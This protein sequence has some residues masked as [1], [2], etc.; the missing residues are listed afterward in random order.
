MSATHVAIVTEPI[1]VAALIERVR[2]GGVGAISLFLG[3]V[4]DL[5]DGKAVSGIDYEAYQ[6]MAESELLAI[7][8]LAVSEWPGLRLAVEHRIGTLGIGDISVA[9]AASHARRAPALD[10]ARDTIERLKVRVPIWKREHY[11]NGDRA[12]VD[13]TAATAVA[14]RP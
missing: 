6:P 11:V 14:P 13:P 8:Q 12:W 7:A 1:D 4:R 9:I 2:D 10:G 3:T 5:N